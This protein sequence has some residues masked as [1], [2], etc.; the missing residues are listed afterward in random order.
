METP[1]HSKP[2]KAKTFSLV[3]L[4]LCLP[5]VEGNT[6]PHQV[7]RITWRGISL[8]RYPVLWAAIQGLTS[9]NP[10]RLL[11][12][13]WVVYNP[14]TGKPL[15]SSSNVAPKGTWWPVLTF[16]LCVLAANTYGHSQLSDFTK[17]PR[18]GALGLF[19]WPSVAIKG[20]TVCGSPTPVYVC[21]GGNWGQGQSRECGGADSFYCAAWG[22]ETTGT[23]HWLTDPVK[24]LIQVKLPQYF[25]PCKT[26]SSKPGQCFP[27][28]IKFTDEGKKVTKWDAGKTWGLRL[29]Q[30]GYDNGF[31]F[32]LKLQL[33]PHHVAPKVSVGPNQVLQDQRG[34]TQAK[35]KG[36][37]AASP[38]PKTT[39]AHLTK[40]PEPVSKAALTPTP[41]K[42]P[43]SGDRLMHL[44]EA[45][46]RALNATNPAATEA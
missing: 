28:Q 39:L 11:N 41:D 15:N 36:P 29:Y 5:L 38:S 22:C 32:G 17:T 7:H 35:D 4:L 16:D 37:P 31:Q 8:L 26:L 1:P 34:P 18:F 21:P 9:A 40:S 42:P 3:T 2:L 43:G 10:H 14:G 27:L 19:S 20:G 45:A 46:F 23:V 24:D 33:G 44:I 30:T 13:S 25:P 6:S 12:M